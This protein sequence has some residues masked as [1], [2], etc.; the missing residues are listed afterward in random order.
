MSDPRRHRAAQL[1]EKVLEELAGDSHGFGAL[2]RQ[3]Q[4]RVLAPV[5]Q[6]QLESALASLRKAGRIVYR[7]PYWERVS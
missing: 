6:S 1:R 7:R 2:R 4:R 5:T 3:V